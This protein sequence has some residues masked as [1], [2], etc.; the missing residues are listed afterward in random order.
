MKAE[1]FIDKIDKIVAAQQD[2]RP[3]YSITR[4][5]S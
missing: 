5:N 3:E 2:R 1:V 4:L